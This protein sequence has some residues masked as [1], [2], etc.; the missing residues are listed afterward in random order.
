MFKIKIFFWFQSIDSENIS[1]ECN[2]LFEANDPNG[3]WTA[4]QFDY[5]ASGE[6]EPDCQTG[7]CCLAEC[8]T[9]AGYIGEKPEKEKILKIYEDYNYNG[10]PNFLKEL[11]MPVISESFDFCERLG[12]NI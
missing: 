6:C 8:L 7:E 10:C 4:P 9:R 11:W 2:S 5:R 1:Q 12:I 3:C